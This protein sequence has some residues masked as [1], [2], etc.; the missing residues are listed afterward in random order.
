MKSQ[1]ADVCNDELVNDIR[2]I[3]RTGSL[4]EKL[5]TLEFVSSCFNKDNTMIKVLVEATKNTKEPVI[6]DKAKEL[7]I[8]NMDKFISKY[9]SEQYPTFIGAHYDDMIQA[10]R[11]GVII[12]LE[13]YNP[14]IAKPTTFFVL[15]IK[16]EVSQYI[17]NYVNG[18]STYY[19]NEKYKINKA[20]NL[21][22]KENKEINEINISEITGIS[23]ENVKQLRNMIASSNNVTFDEVFM[24]KADENDTPE[25]IILNKE[26]GDTLNNSIEKYLT[27]IEKR[28]I[29]MYYGLDY[30]NQNKTKIFPT[31]KALKNISEILD[32][33]YDKVRKYHANALRKLY[34]AVCR[35]ELVT[36]LSRTERILNTQLIPMVSAE[37]GNEIIQ[38]IKA[39]ESISDV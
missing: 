3:M 19:A 39:S 2:N 25:Q 11:M 35:S 24:N 13:K 33:P 9:V 21:L 10:A 29:T 14:E 30:N 37:E 36:E 12:G 16:H 4:M 6:C 1:C 8:K 31:K 17:N 27:D 34:S 26:L 32:I 23:I 15:Y 22:E 5:D 18:L 20:I 28:I 38:T 7:F